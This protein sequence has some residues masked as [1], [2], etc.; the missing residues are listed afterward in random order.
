MRKKAKSKRKAA[1]AHDTSPK[2]IKYVGETVE[3]ENDLD[4]SGFNST[5]GESIYEDFDFAQ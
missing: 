5:Q 2:K 4:E 3:E 1:L